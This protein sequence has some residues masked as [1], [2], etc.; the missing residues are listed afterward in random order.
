MKPLAVPQIAALLWAF[1]LSTHIVRADPRPPDNTPN[2]PSQAQAL[3]K[4]V[5]LRNAFKQWGLPIKGQLRR[6]TCAVFTFT[7]ALEY[8]LAKGTGEIGARLSEEYLVMAQ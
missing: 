8:A 4:I 1:S 6:D 5:D 7:G 3:P 2:S